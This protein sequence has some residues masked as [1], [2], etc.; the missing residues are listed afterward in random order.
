MKKDTDQDLDL[1]EEAKKT[2]A[3]AKNW[4]LEDVELMKAYWHDQMGYTEAWVDANWHLV[5]DESEDA[6]MLALI[7]SEL[8]FKKLFNTAKV[9]I[10]ITEVNGREID[11]NKEGLDIIGYKKEELKK[12]EL[13]QEK[14]IA[15]TEDKLSEKIKSPGVDFSMCLDKFFNNESGIVTGWL[16]LFLETVFS[17]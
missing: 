2:L 8:R 16:F 7:E 12:Q 3:G 11:F 4:F 13:A 9:A 14:K 1:V 17:M 10:G 5:K 15:E 6:D